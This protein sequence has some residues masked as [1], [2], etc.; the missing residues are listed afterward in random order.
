[1]VKR[2][3]S[4]LIVILVTIS[5]SAG[6]AI[7]AATDDIQLSNDNTTVQNKLP[8]VRVYCETSE[9]YPV[10]GISVAIN[11]YEAEIAK[12][13]T[14]SKFG[15][16]VDYF[17]LVDVSAS[18]E[19]KDFDEVKKT[20]IDFGKNSLSNN[21]KVFLV[22]FGEKVYQKQAT[23]Y[24]TPGS[25]EFS[26]AV[27]SLEGEDEYTNLFNA[28]DTVASMIDNELS[29]ELNRSVVLLITDG[30]DD[31]TGGYKNKEE[32]SKSIKTLNTPLYAFAINGTK[33]SK[34]DLGELARSLNGRLYTGNLLNDLNSLKKSIDNTLTIDAE[35]NNAADIGSSFDIEVRVNGVEKAIEKKN[36]TS[37]KSGELKNSFKYN[38]TKLSKEYWWVI[39]IVAVALIALFLFLGIKRH[40]G[41]VKVD[42]ETVFR[43]NV[44]QRQHISVNRK[45]VITL[46]LT[47]SVDGSDMISHDVELIN[48]II[49]GRSNIC[50]L[51]VDDPTMARQ[52]FAMEYRDGRMYIQDLNSTNGTILNGIR[53]TSIQELHRGDTI[54]AGRSKI[55]LDW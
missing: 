51:Y 8:H 25:K 44:T 37:N 18:I 12:A 41:I 55:V 21:D 38:A 4:I 13:D 5:I 31:T 52:N 28:I 42:G 50:D 3:I 23:D 10:E 26:N 27:M 48:S 15:E 33:K 40:K 49:V 29:E 1:M 6:F 32:A 9:H 46:H 53:I 39:A 36:I 14:F 19:K 34:D 16:G 20:L 43:D 30:M 54:V 7:A 35:A 47:M 22:P 45:N 17:V 24:Y 11:G 2:I